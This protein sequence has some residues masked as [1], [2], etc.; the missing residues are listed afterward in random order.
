MNAGTESVDSG[1]LALYQF[2]YQ[3]LIGAS[4]LAAEIETGTWLLLKL[5]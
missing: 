1:H 4:R 5:S 2:G 3:A